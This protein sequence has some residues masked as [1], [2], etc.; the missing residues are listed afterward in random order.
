MAN[1]RNCEAP[2]FFA[3][4]RRWFKWVP[5][6][7]TCLRGDEEEH[8]AG[9]FRMEHHMRHRCGFQAAPPS[10]GPQPHRVLFVE[11]EAP[12]E[13]VRAAFLALAKVFHPDHGGSEEAMRE[14]NEAY[15]AMLAVPRP[16]LRP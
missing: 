1:C 10:D 16:P 9:V 2:I 13:V 11:K 5:V 3:Y 6:D 15:E 8:E 12:V 7:M 4:D 14:L